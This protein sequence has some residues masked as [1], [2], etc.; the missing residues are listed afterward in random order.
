[1]KLI[2]LSGGLGNQM[3]QYAFYLSQAALHPH[4]YM[5]RRKLRTIP[6]HNGFELESVFGIHLPEDTLKIEA[7]TSLPVAGKIALHV[8]FPH[9]YRE[10][11]QYNP[12][13]NRKVFDKSVL[14]TRYVGYWQSEGYFSRVKQQVLEAF[15]F[16]EARISDRTLALANDI[17]SNP[18]K[19][20]A[21]HVRL[22]DYCLYPDLNQI[23]TPE[24]YREA[25]ERISQMRPDARLLLFSDEPDAATEILGRDVQVVDWN[26]G[27][28]SWQDMF[29]MSLCHGLVM[30][31]SSFSWWSG[32]LNP[33]P[34]K[35]VLL[36]A[37]WN[38]RE[39]SPEVAAEGWHCI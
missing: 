10:R 15:R 2:T 5:T 9:K 26:K 37:R 17:R 14:G 22:G 34:E 25:L 33:H 29:L 27:T 12:T 4:V 8:L 31:N 28:D 7:L 19:F 1:M 36:P 3:F 6:D 18:Q 24:Y 16:D 23:C 32:Y 35:F 38:V 39:T 20:V 11:L 13:A 30:A 21:V